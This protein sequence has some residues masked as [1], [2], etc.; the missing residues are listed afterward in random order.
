M[1]E[2]G[3]FGAEAVFRDV[4]T[5]ELSREELQLCEEL[6][7]VISESFR[8]RIIV[9]KEPR[10]KRSRGDRSDAKKADL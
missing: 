8:E 4:F 1:H 3:Y 10:R 7:V 6:P 5:G 9:T 2:P